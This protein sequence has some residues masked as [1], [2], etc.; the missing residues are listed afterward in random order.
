MRWFHV[1]SLGLKSLLSSFTDAITKPNNNIDK[2]PPTRSS[3]YP[4]GGE[5]S[6]PLVETHPAAF[7]GQKEYE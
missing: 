3:G 4:N 2:T 7:S 5:M 6:L 1:R